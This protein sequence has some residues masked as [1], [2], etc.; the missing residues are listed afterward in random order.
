MSSTVRIDLVNKKVFAE[1]T[2]H[3]R[4]VREDRKLYQPPALNR[5]YKRVSYP[6]RN[7]NVTFQFL[8]NA[9]SLAGSGMEQSVVT[10]QIVVLQPELG[11]C[12]AQEVPKLIFTSLGSNGG[13]SLASFKYMPKICHTLKETK[14]MIFMCVRRKLLST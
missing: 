7:T 3:F 4:Y 8:V 2:V 6:I 5:K 14:K 12:K 1:K 13:V 9:P 11:M 10:S